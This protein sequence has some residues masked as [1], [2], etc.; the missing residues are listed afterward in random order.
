MKHRLQ[1]GP[2]R[3]I[4]ITLDLLQTIHRTKCVCQTD[5][6]VL[7]LDQT[8]GV[9]FLQREIIRSNLQEIQF[10]KKLKQRAFQLLDADVE[11][12]GK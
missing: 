12:H 4:I 8:V 9:A 1:P 3:R 6:V 5:L 10:K 11:S 2:S 7:I